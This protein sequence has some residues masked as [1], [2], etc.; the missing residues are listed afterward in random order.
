MCNIINKVNT[1]SLFEKKKAVVYRLTVN[2]IALTIFYDT[3]TVNT[4]IN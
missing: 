4:A 2:Y 1:K 3:P